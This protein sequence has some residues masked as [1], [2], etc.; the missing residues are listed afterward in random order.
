MSE[1]I[2]SNFSVE[3]EPKILNK[4]KNNIQSNL[5]QDQ[6]LSGLGFPFNR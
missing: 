5:V 1:N 4:N 6:V 2:N 3:I